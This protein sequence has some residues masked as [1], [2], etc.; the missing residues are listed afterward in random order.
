MTIRDDIAAGL[1]VFAKQPVAGRVKTRLAQRIGPRA[2]AA[3]HDAMLECVVQ[4]WSRLEAA[5]LTLAVSPDTWVAQARRRWP[6]VA[7][8]VPQGRGDLG[9]RITRVSAAQWRRWPRPLVLLG[10]DS[11]DLPAGHMRHALLVV[12]S[13]RAVMAPT[14][15]GGYCLLAI[16]RPLPG[17]FEGVDWGGPRVAEQT[18][19]AAR[20][21]GIELVELPPAPDIDTADDLKA[22]RQ[23]LVGACDPALRQLARKLSAI[24]PAEGRRT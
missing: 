23:R 3:V 7:D 17:L 22:L 15:D 8:V 13:G 5:R 21:W 9:E 1:I 4:R 11:P 24:L 12:A 2:A 16:P 6:E 10:A 14:P 18:R 20:R 19:E